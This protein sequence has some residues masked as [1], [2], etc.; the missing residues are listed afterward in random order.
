MTIVLSP[1]EIADLTDRVKFAAQARQLAHMRIPFT[2]RN[3]GSLAVLRI[4]VE[5][6]TAVARRDE[7]PRPRVRFD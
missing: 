4:H 1:E 2:P 6:L 5:T 7:A 3:D